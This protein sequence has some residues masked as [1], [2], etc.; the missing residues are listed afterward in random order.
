M[1]SHRT[2]LKLPVFDASLLVTPQPTST[3]LHVTGTM[4]PGPWQ[5]ARVV[6]VGRRGCAIQ[7]LVER[8]VKPIVDK[9]NELQKKAT[10]VE[11]GIA[12]LRAKEVDWQR[13]KNEAEELV[14]FQ[15]AKKEESRLNICALR[16]R[17]IRGIES[18]KAKMSDIKQKAQDIG[19]VSIDDR[20]ARVRESTSLE[21]YMQSCPNDGS[22]LRE[23]AELHHEDIQL[24]D[25]IKRIKS[26]I[27][28]FEQVAE[29]QKKLA[30]DAMQK[31]QNLQE[32]LNGKDEELQTVSTSLEELQKQRKDNEL[33]QESLERTVKWVQCV[34]PDVEISTEML[35]V[36]RLQ[37]Q[38]SMK[39][40]LFSSHSVELL[41]L[42]CSASELRALAALA[43]PDGPDVL[44]QLV[45]AGV[46][47]EKL[48]DMGF[49][50][51]D[52]VD[53]FEVADLVNATF[54]K[55]ELGACPKIRGDIGGLK[56]AGYESSELKAMGFQLADL[57]GHYNAAEMLGAGWRKEELLKH[58]PQMVFELKQHGY[59]AV[60]LKGM[61]FSV[62]ELAV[63]YNAHDLVS[64]EFPK[65]ELLHYTMIVPELKQTGLSARDLRR[66]GFTA[67]ELEIFTPLELVRAGFSEDE[68]AMAGQP[69]RLIE[70]AF[71]E[72]SGSDLTDFKKEELKAAGFT[73]RQLFPDSLGPTAWFRYMM[74]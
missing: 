65:D 69:R 37:R 17:K 27:A 49:E 42:N 30:D 36:L 32:E 35:P 54:S 22:A 46:S 16:D 56:Q 34:Y 33:Y 44:E 73:A 24:S 50:C 66:L 21:Q 18:Q 61:G 5:V 38:E 60:E 47:A 41:R 43:R 23:Y 19:D 62:R 13:R 2:H 10:E 9:E 52:L 48:K 28:K 67:Q 11:A 45:D 70:A 51:R 74:I 40:A 8:R 12:A 14:A 63:S 39:A 20:L 71:A 26:G 15:M 6:S 55:E 31:L 29:Q 58:Y 53:F 7:A 57:T 4:W 64:A 68:L 25:E 59:Q 1:H 72:A 3:S